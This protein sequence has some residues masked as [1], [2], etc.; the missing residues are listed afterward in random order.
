MISILITLT[1]S[2]KIGAED[3]VDVYYYNLAS[4]DKKMMGE[5]ESADDV[6]N[7]MKEFSEENPNKIIRSTLSDVKNIQSDLDQMI[8][9]WKTG[10]LAELEIN[11]GEKMRK[12][13]PSAYKSLVVDRNKRWFPHLEKM[14]VTPEVELVMVGSLHLS[15]K[16][17]LL[18]MLKKSNYHVKPLTIN[19][20]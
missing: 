19:N 5:L 11:M 13:T 10:N 17:G 14:L 3:G 2:K 8:M 18:A 7:Y 12:E 6:I 9:L 1:E 20:L 16:N 4:K 15:G